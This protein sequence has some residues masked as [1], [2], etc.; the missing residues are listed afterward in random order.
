MQS[1]SIHSAKTHLSSLISG[2]LRSGESV[3]IQR[4]GEA[5]VEMRPLSSKSRL[6]T[7]KALSRIKI[8]EDPT[9][10]TTGEWDNV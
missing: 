10:P 6:K 5:V 8:K 9:L 7:D 4:H 1:V 3:I 2:I